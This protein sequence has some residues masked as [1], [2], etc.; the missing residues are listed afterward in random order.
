MDGSLHRLAGHTDTYR[1]S[2][3]GYSE[4]VALSQNMV[5]CFV[6]AEL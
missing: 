2:L 3:R 5:T 6:M 4:N 1:Y